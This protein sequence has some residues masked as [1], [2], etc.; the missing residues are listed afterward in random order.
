MKPERGGKSVLQ[1]SVEAVTGGLEGD[2]HTGHSRR[3]QILL[4]SGSVMDELE[5]PPASIFENVVVDDIDV[6]ALG[7]GTPIRIGSALV[8]VTL[9]CEPCVQMDRLRKG[10][11]DALQ[12]RRGMFVK[13]L[14]PGT[15]R[16][17]DRVEILCRQSL[18][19]NL[20]K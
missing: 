14:K 12:N 8:E 16:V 4:M 20:P 7:E 11:Q 1:E 6:M 17:G 13:V 18:E 10:L 9:P 15:I 3:R 5:L 2:H 19:E